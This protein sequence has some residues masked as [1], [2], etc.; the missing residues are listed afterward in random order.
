MLSAYAKNHRKVIAQLFEGG[1]F[2]MLIVSICGGETL[3]FTRS[4][5]N[6]IIDPLFACMVVQIEE[7]SVL[8]E[9]SRAEGRFQPVEIL[10][11][12]RYGDLQIE[13][14]ENRAFRVRPLRDEVVDKAQ[15]VQ[16]GLVVVFTLTHVDDESQ[17][18]L[19]VFLDAVLPGDAETRT[20][21]NQMLV[22]ESDAIGY[23]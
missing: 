15:F 12:A 11:Q 2:A 10:G 18:R 9:G 22:K 8:E 21:L 5:E 17:G 19:F 4:E 23:V 7:F 13:P 6:L 20:L 16:E 3:S 1:A 14:G